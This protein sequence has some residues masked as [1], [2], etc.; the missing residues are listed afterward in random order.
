MSDVAQ[1]MLPTFEGLLV[2]KFELSFG[3]KVEMDQVFETDREFIEK[4]RLGQRITLTIEGVIV[5]RPFAWREGDNNGDDR[6]TS[7]AKLRVESVRLFD[8]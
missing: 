4:C 5:A 3:G 2:D 7:G 8:D 1:L 6:V